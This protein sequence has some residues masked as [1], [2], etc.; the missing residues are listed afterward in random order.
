[1][2]KWC[3]VGGW[4]GTGTDAVSTGSKVLITFR[5]DKALSDKGFMLEFWSIPKSKLLCNLK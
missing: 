5:S 1:M 2:K 4:P 3:G